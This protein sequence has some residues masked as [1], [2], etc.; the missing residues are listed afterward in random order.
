MITLES[1]KQRIKDYFTW[2][3]EEKWKESILSKKWG[4]NIFNSIETLIK[5]WYYWWAYN[6]EKQRNEWKNKKMLWVR[7]NSYKM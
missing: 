3:P 4:K 7:I 1:E 2:R 5:K 6:F